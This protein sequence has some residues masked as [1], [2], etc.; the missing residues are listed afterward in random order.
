M[1]RVTIR[2]FSDAPIYFMGGLYALSFS[3]EEG[4]FDMSRLESPGLPLLSSHED[5]V[6]VGTI[7]GYSVA[8]PDPEGEGTAAMML[9]A[10]LL[11]DKELSP[12]AKAVKQQILN[13]TMKGT[14]GKWAYDIADDDVLQPYE[15]PL[16]SEP[17]A[18]AWTVKPW[19]FIED[20]VTNIPLV[21]SARITSVTASAEAAGNL[22]V[23]SALM[24]RR[25]AMADQ[26]AA[27]A[28]PVIDYDALA[29]AMLRAQAAA[30]TAAE[31]PAQ[32][33]TATATAEAPAATVPAA[34]PAAQATA[35]SP[36]PTGV[37]ASIAAELAAL[38]AS[39][40][41]EAKNNAAFRERINSLS[42]QPNTIEQEAAKP[43]NQVYNIEAAMRMAGMR[44]G[45]LPPSEKDYAYTTKRVKEVAS[46]VASRELLMPQPSTGMTTGLMLTRDDL[47]A[48]NP[49]QAQAAVQMSNVVQ[50]ITRTELT[51]D[52]NIEAFPYRERLDVIRATGE[53]QIPYTNTIP[54]V[55]RPAETVATTES[56]YGTDKT[57]LT[58]KAASIYVRVT[59][60]AQFFDPTIEA[61]VRMLA[62]RLI[63]QD[64]QSFVEAT[65]HAGNAP[66]GFYA[67]PTADKFVGGAGGANINR[68]ATLDLE[69]D[70]ADAI[71]NAGYSAFYVAH[72]D[73][74]KRLRGILIDDGSGLYLVA[75]D[76]NSGMLNNG[77]SQMLPGMAIFR[78]SLIAEHGMVLVTGGLY[79]FAEWQGV[80]MTMDRE[81]QAENRYVRYVFDSF[82]DG[83][84]IF[85]GAFPYVAES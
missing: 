36:A 58:P 7:V 76:M 66:Q 32:T 60:E 42:I 68:G 48:V 81:S 55:Y 62:N 57:M 63:R 54:V 4:A 41:T 64:D 53:M 50:T 10:D 14:S 6:R 15:G 23:L 83:A 16:E 1:A 17:L 78:S 13:G 12:E 25:A 74:Y 44:P 85:R 59:R 18:G 33:A 79:K 65:Y 26:T 69:A 2:A 5:R 70:L 34:P 37:D 20:S 38:K 19:A 43:G 29:A 82:R 39:M 40:E 67:L 8:R 28:A 56:E 3:L 46:L 71:K 11:D 61:E 35:P 27:Q 75:G 49:G 47:Q 52:P 80:M 21:Q 73:I 72:G 31:A 22:D 30:Q 45:V 77:G 84:A 24:A 9:T 51:R